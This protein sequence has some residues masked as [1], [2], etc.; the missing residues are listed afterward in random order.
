MFTGRHTNNAFIRRA[1]WILK[2]G[3]TA[4]C[5]LYI[6]QK[7]DLQKTTQ[8]LQQTSGWLLLPAVLLYSLSKLIAACRLNYFFSNT[9]IWLSQRYNIRL[10]W[11]GMFYNLFL[12]GGIGGDAWKVWI[13]TRQTGTHWRQAA[14]AV[15]L[16]R[17]SGLLGLGLLLAV[18]MLPY[19]QHSLLASAVLITCLLTV[20]VYRWIL[21]KYFPVFLPGF[22]PTLLLAICVQA[23]QVLECYL[24]MA[25]LG[26]P[27]STDAYILLFLISSVFTVLPLSIGGLGV[28]EM[29][30]LEGARWLSLDSEKA[31]LLSF[32]FYLSSLISAAPGLAGLFRPPADSPEK[33]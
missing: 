26:I 7:L 28:R 21:K 8:A 32:L 12:P 19:I 16:D 13:L 18:F 17:V 27:L 29:V 10:Y 2:L 14:A 11:T 5:I 9:G 20:P 25:A 1:K 24:L 15:I 22:G 6:T 33:K 30:F 31:V 3:I 23:V 4:L